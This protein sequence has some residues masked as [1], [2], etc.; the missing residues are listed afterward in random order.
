MIFNVELNHNSIFKISQI[1]DFFKNDK[2]ATIGNG[3][4]FKVLG[5]IIK[6]NWHW[7]TSLQLWTIY[8]FPSQVAS[9]NCDMSKN[10]GLDTSSWALN[11][12][13]GI[14]SNGN[15]EYKLD[16]QVQ[17]GDILV[18]FLLC[19]KASFRPA[20]FASRKRSGTENFL[21]QYILQ[22]KSKVTYS[23]LLYCVLHSTSEWAFKAG[24]SHWGSQ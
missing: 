22:I 23:T 21:T 15:V 6:S 2:T 5:F 13:Q 24:S 1:P 8:F 11:S 10:L 4:Q 9:P 14:L 17:E 19:F 7:T 12:E 16:Q 18:R 3:L 20:R